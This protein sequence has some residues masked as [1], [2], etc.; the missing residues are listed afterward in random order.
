MKYKMLNLLLAL[1]I[2][3]LIHPGRA[4]K[5]TKLGNLRV[6]QA[7]MQ[8]YIQQDLVK[9]MSNL[10][11]E[12]HDDNDLMMIDPHVVCERIEHA[13]LQRVSC[14]CT[15]TWLTMTFGFECSQHEPLDIAGYTGIPEYSGSFVVSSMPHKANIIAGVCVIQSTYNGA[16]VDDICVEGAFCIR[17]EGFGFC[18]C[19]ASVGNDKCRCSECPG[20][21]TYDCHEY[22]VNLPKLCIPLPYV[23]G[24]Q[25]I[26]Q[27][28][29]PISLVEEL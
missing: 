25:P 29:H 16:M 21:V 5:Q 13:F 27:S 14:H 11:T 23:R 3:L 2:A 17:K 10:D 12:F 28:I 7:K 9:Y 20:G 1:S 18:G 26:H 8:E 15:F 24:I 19:Q 4:V 6:A 22:N